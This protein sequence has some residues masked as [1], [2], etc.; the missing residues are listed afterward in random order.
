MEKAKTV[1]VG[2]VIIEI[3]KRE[4]PLTLSYSGGLTN[5]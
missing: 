4:I 1:K 5:E 2:K 3:G